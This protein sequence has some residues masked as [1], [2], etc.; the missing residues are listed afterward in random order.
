MHFWYGFYVLFALNTNRFSYRASLLLDVR[1]IQAYRLLMK[2]AVGCWTSRYGAPRV[3]VTWILPSGHFVSEWCTRETRPTWHPPRMYLSCL[4]GGLSSR[5]S[6]LLDVS[7]I[8]A[9]S[10]LVKS[11]A[12]FWN[13]RYGTQRVGTAPP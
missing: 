4:I 2:G 13:S 3:G 7:Y 9:Y 5:G 11:A 10:L 1:Y 8:Q 12:C 6:L